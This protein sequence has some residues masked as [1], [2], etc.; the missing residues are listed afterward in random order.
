[1][2]THEFDEKSVKECADILIQSVK[3][4][5]K[6]NYISKNQDISIYVIDAP[7]VHSAVA[8]FGEHIQEQTNAHSIVQVNIDVGNP[9]PDALPQIE[10][11][12]GNDPVII[13]VEQV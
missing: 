7:I 2:N 11:T 6:D 8:Q 12:I 1:M 4:I 13:A 9:M 3:Q 5:R 10:V